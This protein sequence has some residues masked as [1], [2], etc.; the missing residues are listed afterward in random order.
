MLFCINTSL[1]MAQTSTENYVVTE[2]MLNSEGSHITSVQYYDGLGRQVQTVQ[3]GINANH[4]KTIHAQQDYDACGRFFKAW[5]PV[6][7]MSLNYNSNIPDQVSDQLAYSQTTYD[8]TDRPIYVSTPGSDMSGRGKSIEYITNS[9]NSVKRYR[10]SDSGLSQ[11]GYYPAGTLDGIKTTDEDGRTLVVFKDM[12]GSVVL[13]R[14]ASHYDTYY[15][16]NNLHQL[17]FVLSPRYQYSAHKA[18]YGYEYRYD[19]RGNVAK[20]ILP[21]CEYIQYW[22]DQANRL[23]YMQDANLRKKGKYRFFLY[24]A[25]G[26]L[27]MQGLSSMA[28]LDLS[29]S[30][31]VPVATFNLATSGISGT[32]YVVNVQGL[33]D[34]N[35]VIEIVNYYDNYNFLTA[36]NLNSFSFASA[37]NQ[38]VQGLITG[39]IT[40]ASNGSLIYSV[41]YYN[42]RGLLTETRTKGLSNINEF[43][44]TQYSFTDKPV[45]S[46]YSVT[47]DGQ[48]L[49]S[50]TSTLAYDSS[51][52]KLASSNMS[53]TSGSAAKSALLAYHTYDDMGRLSH[54]NRS[55]NVGSVNYGYDVRGWLTNISTRNFSEELF[56][57]DSPWGDSCYNGNI[58]ALR[59]KDAGYKPDHR[60]MKY[61]G[62][63]FTYDHLNRLTAAV[64]GEGEGLSTNKNRY[65]EI[66]ERYDENGNIM[67][68][69]RRGLKQDGVY[70]TIDNLTIHLNGNQVME[71]K[72]VALR[73]TR[74]GTL[75]FDNAN[76]GNWYQYQYNSDG[77]LMID[78]SRGIALIEY[79][80]NNN[81]QRIQFTNGNVIKYVYTSTGIKLRTIHYT[82]VP[83]IT[84]PLGAK[85]ELILGPSGD[86]LS[87]D[88]TEYHAGLIF[89]NG[90]PSMYPFD[91]GYC[92]LRTPTGIPSIA[93]HYYDR[94]HLG[95][96][97]IVVNAS[98][99]EV[100]QVTNYYPFGTVFSDSTTHNPGFQ[101][102]KYNGKELDLAHGLNTYDYGARQY[103][104]IL[105]KWDRID[106]LAET[107]YNVSPYAYCANNPVRFIDPDGKDYDVYYDGKSFIISA[108]Y[109]TDEFSA[110]SANNAVAFWNGLNGKYTMDGLP[111]NFAL[112]V[113]VIS[114]EEI[115]V[116]VK[117]DR[118][119]N[120][121]AN[122][123]VSGNTYILSD[124]S[125]AN[126]NGE[127]KSGRVVTV[128]KNKATPL[129]GAHEIGHT[130]GMQ[131]SDAGLMTAASSDPQRSSKVSKGE[132]KSMIKNAVKGKPAKDTNGTPAGKGYFHNTSDA[133][134]VKFKY[135]MEDKMK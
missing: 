112:N 92:S 75:D 103:D 70:G 72:D 40:R 52:D 85:R 61:R 27:V 10:A 84:V 113:T 62:Y 59:W 101:K 38:N 1:S 31:N 123:T 48:T 34:S 37:S 111:V 18:I 67:E 12:M 120:G 33:V 44:A 6:S 87:A 71:A 76:G 130:L 30:D 35:S 53:I 88:T 117:T 9:A 83:N 26:R 23:L 96:N 24:D 25:L 19:N 65:N 82:A 5:L 39:T 129:T 94:D 106:P 15:V 126:I 133:P 50:A 95:N 21:Q 69:S 105:P 74:P 63:Q 132:I 121:K 47:K 41:M 56:Y 128:N 125:D 81:P 93:F 22:H 98:S 13:E 46:T 110:E 43:T 49:F 54:T 135:K 77:A 55:S 14:R 45:E 20:K 115:P 32:G 60:N 17:R 29:E 118:F 108:T 78:E 109:Y 114:S 73:V 97:R 28:K 99:G 57:A 36:N 42:E 79:D 116:G 91:D 131:H 68:L 8:A 16:Y 58:S 89:I 100:E 107:N 80:D 2:T 7:G 64:Y 4:S 102:F 104:P 127:T 11:D 90:Q 124:I 66:V 119:I 86:V 134:N 3:N 51:C 122:V